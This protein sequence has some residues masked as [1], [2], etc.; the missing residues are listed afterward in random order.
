MAVAFA[1]ALAG[2]LPLAIA[3]GAVFLAVL[4]PRYRACMATIDAI[5]AYDRERSRARGGP[6]AAIRIRALVGSRRYAEARRMLAALSPETAFERFEAA[7]LT[8]LLDFVETGVGS[9]GEPERQLA[10]IPDGGERDY[11]RAALAYEQARVACWRG[12][13]WELPLAAA[14]LTIGSGYRG[15]Q[16]GD[17]MVRIVTA[18]AGVLIAGSGIGFVLG[19]VLG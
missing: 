8:A 9:L 15:A 10:L 14:G 17:R 1:L 18:M 2:V 11:A 4:G 6:Q 5:A 16:L 13:D 3:Y 19:F 7:L 12:G